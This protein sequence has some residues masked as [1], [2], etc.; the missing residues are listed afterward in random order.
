MVPAAGFKTLVLHPS[1][2]L[3]LRPV[4]N[5]LTR[6]FVSP[7]PRKNHPDNIALHC[8]LIFIVLSLRRL[9][10]VILTHLIIPT[11]PPPIRFT[12]HPAVQ[13]TFPYHINLT[14]N[15]NVTTLL[16]CHS[17]PVS[18]LYFHPVA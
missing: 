11:Q 5:D 15:R 6:T 2:F 18:H 10:P 13:H 4:K 16:H 8:V 14:N 3:T 12:E 17:L 9:S 7:P 1:Y